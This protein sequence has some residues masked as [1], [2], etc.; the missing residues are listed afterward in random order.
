MLIIAGLGNPGPQYARNRHNIGFMAIDA[1]AAVHRIGPFRSRFQSQASEGLIASERVL[2]LKPTT[3]MNDSGR[4]V[5]E[6]LRFYKVG[7]ESLVVLHDE[8]DLAPAK[9]RMKVGGGNAGH[10]GLRSITAIC[11][12]DYRRG[13]LGIGHPGDKALVHGYV[14]S[15]FAKAERAWV[16]ALCD[17][18][19]RDAELLVRREDASLQNKV[20]L[21]MTAA[22]F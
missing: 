12:N 20:H 19:A 21:A 1:M 2:L 4:A 11:G 18:I 10:N 13:R 5:G 3:F 16:D 8:L 7:L 6:A 15:D 22:G 14:L 17:N 9:L